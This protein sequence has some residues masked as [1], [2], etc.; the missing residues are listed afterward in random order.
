MKSL[1]WIAQ[2]DAWQHART[3]LTVV[4]LSQFLMESVRLEVYKVFNLQ[5]ETISNIL[6]SETKIKDCVEINAVIRIRRRAVE[7]FCAD[8][9][10]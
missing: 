4:M 8:A 10:S 7:S 2:K 6:R 9:E 1:Q 3:A 5:V